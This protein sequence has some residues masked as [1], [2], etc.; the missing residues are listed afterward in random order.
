MGPQEG[1]HHSIEEAEEALRSLPD[2]YWA[3]LRR[4]AVWKLADNCMADAD[5]V[6]ADIWERFIRGSR[7]W[8][9]GVPIATCFWNAVKS[10]INGEW[11]RHKR[12]AAKQYAPVTADGEAADAFEDIAGSVDDPLEELAG[13]PERLRQ[14]TIVD[15]ISNHFAPDEA[16]TAILIGLEQNMPAREIQEA[17]NLTETQYDSARKKLRR[18]INKQYPDGW[19]PHEPK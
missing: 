16:V 14:Q 17:F 4:W 9:I 12:H 10:A 19:Q 13:A 5:D 18:F 7:R 11:D 2:R 3:R 15:H 6:V 8:P 1:Q